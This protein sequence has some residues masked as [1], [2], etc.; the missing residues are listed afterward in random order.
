M[1][2][3]FYWLD[4]PEFV[5]SAWTLGIAHSPGHPLAALLGRLFCYLP[6]GTISF[7]VALASAA[8]AMIAVY[9]VGLLT[10]QLVLRLSDDQ[11]IRRPWVLA[12]ASSVASLCAAFSYALWFQA[13]RAEVYA[14]NLALVLGA[15]CLLVRWERQR[16]QHQLLWGA[17]F[18]AGLGPV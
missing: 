13:I 1:G 14:L 5:T 7:R 18:V 4:S 9:L 6:L 8:S 15:C 12:F 17:G 10:K 11:G 16:D 2:A 3:T